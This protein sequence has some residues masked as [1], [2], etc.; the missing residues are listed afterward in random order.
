MDK[1]LD[2]IIDS[3][4]HDLPF[5]NNSLPVRS[6]NRIIICQSCSGK[7][8]IPVTE[9]KG[10]VRGL[11]VEDQQCRNCKGSGRLLVEINIRIKPY[12]QKND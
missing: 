6:S 3:N 4:I 7:G 10:H 12:K 2:Y 5:L 8:Y 9:Y 11:E 1:S